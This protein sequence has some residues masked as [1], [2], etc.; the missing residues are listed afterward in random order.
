MLKQLIIG[1]FPE[2]CYVV[3]TAIEKNL[4]TNP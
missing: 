1:R 3:A 4:D 2:T